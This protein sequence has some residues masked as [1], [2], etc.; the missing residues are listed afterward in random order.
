MT[1]DI[2]S[3]IGDGVSSIF[4]FKHQIYEK[5]ELIYLPEWKDED[6]MKAAWDKF[7]T[8]KEW[9]EI[10]AETSKLHGSFVN[11]IEDKKLKLTE[12]SPQKKLLK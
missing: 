10:K 2:L 6:T 12:F 1:F 5:T 3:S 8:D 9:K 7:M 4:R 11:N